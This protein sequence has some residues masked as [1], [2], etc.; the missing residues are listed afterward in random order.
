MGKRLLQK[1][2]DRIVFETFSIPETDFYNY[3]SNIIEEN[4]GA[5]EG[6]FQKLLS[7][8]NRWIAWYKKQHSDDYKYDGR[9]WDGDENEKETLIDPDTIE[10][11][12]YRSF[13][14]NRHIDKSFFDEQIKI[15]DGLS[16]LHNL[17]KGMALI[18]DERKKI[19]EQ[20]KQLK[21]PQKEPKTF[22]SLFIQEEYAEK[23][24]NIFTAE[25][26]LT[27]GNWTYPGNN[28]KSIATPF[29]VLQD[30]FGIIKNDTRPARTK[31]RIWCNR[32]GVSPNNNNLKSLL[33]NPAD[34]KNPTL[35]FKQ[36]QKE[37]YK[38]F[39]PLSHPIK[40]LD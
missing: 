34:G 20:L 24:I 26:Y 17:R 25:G 19:A 11:S 37:F 15:I 6:I 39:E 1:D 23:I 40:D 14:I 13:N 28:N 12:L 22:E 4:L 35:K 33:N 16:K 21:K 8:V 5:N 27:S 3:Y 36:E 32:L 31:L 30:Y 7:A 2:Y 9:T 38:L 29:F 10:I 18:E